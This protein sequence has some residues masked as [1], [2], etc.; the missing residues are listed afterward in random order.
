VLLEHDRQDSLNAE[1]GP[2]EIHVNLFADRVCVSV[3][4][5]SGEKL[6]QIHFTQQAVVS[7]ILRI[8]AGDG[9]NQ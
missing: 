1:N 3:L 4:W 2:H 8:S 6:A 5:R 9:N 7:R